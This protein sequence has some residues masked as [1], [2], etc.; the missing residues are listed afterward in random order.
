MINLPKTSIIYGTTAVAKSA[1]VINY[2]IENN[3]SSVIFLT[4]EMSP[5]DIEYRMTLITNDI[6]T[7]M[8]GNAS[9][10]ELTAYKNIN[11]TKTS[12]ITILNNREGVISI[13]NI[14]DAVQS[15]SSSGIDNIIVII[16]S[17]TLWADSIKTDDDVI[18]NGLLEIQ[19]EY[20]CQLVLVCHEHRLSQSARH[21]TDMLIKFNYERG[22]KTIGGKKFVRLTVEKNRF[23]DTFNK[24]VG[25][26]GNKQK[27]EN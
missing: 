2:A 5:I 27:F 15:A 4:S 23:G 21:F 13:D 17:Y 14:K 18:I 19:S 16:D 10:E 6:T 12:H 11:Y 8:L 7:E 1:Y 20:N 24:V 9:P 25:F 22:G 3:N 26:Y